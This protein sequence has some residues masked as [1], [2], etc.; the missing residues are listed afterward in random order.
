MS[1]QIPEEVSRDVV[2]PNLTPADK[3][4]LLTVS[5]GYR[6]KILEHFARNPSVATQALLA[7][8]QAGRLYEVRQIAN[9]IEQ[10]G[11]EYG[12]VKN[13]EELVDVYGERAIVNFFEAGAVLAAIHDLVPIV[14]NL[15]SR[16]S[17]PT[18]RTTTMVAKLAVENGSKRLYERIRSNFPLR[19]EDVIA[20]LELH[21]V[22]AKSNEE[23]Y[24][25]LL[26]EILTKNP[27][28]AQ[29]VEAL[30]ETRVNPPL[31]A[32]HILLS[33]GLSLEEFEAVEDA[34]VVSLRYPKMLVPAAMHN[35]V[36]IFLYVL[37]RLSKPLGAYQAYFRRISEVAP[38]MAVYIP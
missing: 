3:M 18:R 9:V 26:L 25:E 38:E 36:E 35:N 11:E 32:F 27:I 33:L 17:I 29:R 1:R 15:L 23:Q 16:V 2:L 30:D 10:H 13:N 31:H 24:K 19:V 6:E 37:N 7:A 5:Q 4:S 8:V 34:L 22:G 12:T 20:N 21:P 28:M 14:L